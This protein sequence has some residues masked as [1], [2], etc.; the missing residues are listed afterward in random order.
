[1]S[2]RQ[3]GRAWVLA[4]TLPR[5]VAARREGPAPACECVPHIRPLSRW[6]AHRL[7][8]REGEA[9]APPPGAQVWA[10]DAESPPGTGPWDSA[11]RE[12]PPQGTRWQTFV[13]RASD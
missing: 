10:A 11:T 4:S 6:V 7:A 2:Y 5:P 3:D 12:Q 1:M 13:L 8:P 9:C